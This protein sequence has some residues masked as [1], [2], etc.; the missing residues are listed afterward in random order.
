MNNPGGST[1][2]RLAG[3]TFSRIKAQKSCLGREGCLGYHPRPYNQGLKQFDG[4]PLMLMEH[5]PTNHEIIKIFLTLF[6]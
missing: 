4:I 3:T 2:T 5:K 1:L 6:R